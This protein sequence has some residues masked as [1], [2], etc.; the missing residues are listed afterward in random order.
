[1]NINIEQVVLGAIMLDDNI[2]YLIDDLSD[3]HFAN[4]IYKTVY[5]AMI[6]L[7]YDGKIVE[8]ISLRNKLIDMKKFDE[9]GGMSTLLAVSDSVGSSLH[10]MEHIEILNEKLKLR[11]L[12]QISNTMN[13]LV[14]DSEKSDVIAEIIESKLDAIQQ[15]DKNDMKNISDSLLDALNK[16]ESVYENREKYTGLETK[17]SDLDKMTSGLHNSDLMLLAARPAMGKTA[18]AINIAE[19]VAVHGKKS[20][21][22]FSL[23]MS[24]SQLMNRII[25]S[26]AM[27][28]FN[29]LKN[30][31]LSEDDWGKIIES[32]HTLSLT[33]LYID[34][35]PAITPSLILQKCKKLKK[36]KK[37]DLIVIDYLQ[38]LT[39]SRRAE[40]RQ[41]EISEISRNLKKIAKEL[42]VPIIALSQLSRACEQ[43]ADHRPMLSDLRESGAIEQ[44]ADI[45]MFLYRDEY[46]FPDSE[47]KNQAELIIAKHR[48]GETGTIN[49]AWMGQY[50][51]FFNIGKF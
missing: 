9:I 10:I 7:Y 16:I 28:S 2:Q 21:A 48:N 11:Q 50:T 18:F 22:V 8:I 39:L 13:A 45:V 3:E 47:K 42:D 44:D 23:E 33:N 12:Q 49:L 38:L 34:D 19:N 29:S 36:E 17:F 5:D 30:G 32:I 25:S 26:H 51:K 35:T 20:V 27:I 40:S 15:S 41:Q 14:D 46:Y 6:S 24:T 4:P 37:L 31:D 43:R 1:M